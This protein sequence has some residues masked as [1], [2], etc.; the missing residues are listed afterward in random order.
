MGRNKMI[1]VNHSDTPHP[2]IYSRIDKPTSFVVFCFSAFQRWTILYKFSRGLVFVIR[3]FAANLEIILQ[4]NTVPG[5]G[6]VIINSINKYYDLHI[7][8]LST[9]RV[10]VCWV[11]LKLLVRITLG[12]AMGPFPQSAPSLEVASIL[13]R[14][15]NFRK[16]SQL[17]EIGGP[18]GG[19]TFLVPY[20]YLTLLCLFV[21][22]HKV[23][24]FN[25]DRAG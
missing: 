12:S 4:S 2:Q 10:L 5:N 25:E 24:I 18:G 8:C 23:A 1:Q 22:V 9:S 6:I 21:T 16:H 14:S 7:L 13:L 20:Y 17:N 3:I 15:I 11:N 19:S